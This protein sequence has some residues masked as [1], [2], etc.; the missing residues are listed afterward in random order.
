MSKKT[1][2]KVEAEKAKHEKVLFKLT[3]CE[4][5]IQNLTVYGNF[6]PIDMTLWKAIIGFHRQISINLDAESVSYHR[7][8][9]PEGK[10]HSLIPFQKTRKHGLSVKVDWQDERNQKL[11]DEYGAKFKTDFFPACTIHTH[12][13]SSAFESGTD[14]ADEVDN[15]GWHITLGNLISESKYDL[16]FRM[17]LPQLK[18]LKEYV[19]T[20][21]K[22]DLDMG[23]LFKDLKKNQKTIETTPGTE[24]W[25]HLIS[26]VKS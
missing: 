5:H 15:P 18:K 20:G 25:H 10:Y 3:G 24:D 4:F 12:V 1:K 6:K 13:D 7:W 21:S 22:V 19:N 8:H 14:A 2:Q 23:H 11:L 17:R 26:R 9:E 16:D